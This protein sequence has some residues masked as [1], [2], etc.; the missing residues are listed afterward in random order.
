MVEYDAERD[1]LY[2]NKVKPYSEQESEEL[3]YGVIARKQ[4]EGR[5]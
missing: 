3:E 4:K 2:L 5:C 1:I